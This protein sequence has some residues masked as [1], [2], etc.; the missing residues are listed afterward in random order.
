[1]MVF[2]AATRAVAGVPALMLVVLLLLRA[3][4]GATVL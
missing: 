4:V 1:M 3:A 2:A